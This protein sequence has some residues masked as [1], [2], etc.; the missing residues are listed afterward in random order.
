MI[1]KIFYLFEVGA[2]V[3]TA[4]AVLLIVLFLYVYYLRNL[5]KVIRKKWLSLYE[6]LQLRQDML[7]LLIETVRK[8]SDNPHVKRHIDRLIEVRHK[9][10]LEKVPGRFKVELEYDLSAVLKDLFEEVKNMEALQK[11][12]HFLE[13]KHDLRTTVDRIKKAVLE[14]NRVVRKCRRTTFGLGRQLIFEFEG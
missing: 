12:V 9:A 11:D 13:V 6:I 1:G 2:A 7:P 14:Y 8:Y 3:A 10:A 4:A 5:F